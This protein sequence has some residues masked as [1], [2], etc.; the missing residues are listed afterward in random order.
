MN[1]KTLHLGALNAN[2]YIAETGNGQ[3]IAVDIGGTPRMV[4]EYLKMNNLKLTKILLTHGH[5]DH[6][7]GVEAV[8][9]ET[10][11]EVFIHENDVKMLS[12]ADL[13]LRSSMYFLS[14]DQFMPVEK[15]TV[16]H[17]G[18]EI[19]DGGYTF[20]VLHTPGHT[21][22]SVC[23]ITDDAVF[24][25]DTVF[26]CSIGRTDFPD[27][28]V[29]EMIQSIKKVSQIDGDLKLLAGHNEPSTLD[30]ERKNNP[31]MVKYGVQND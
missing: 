22:G 30:Y 26:C 3:C 21:K 23:Y 18:D 6:I 8:R 7:D 28:S 1:I 11:A 24:S 14:S 31:Y 27:G 5:F 10:G 20:R 2:C 29:D 4:I 17:D 25:G 19:K 12:D 16:I 15:Y 13:S 9:R